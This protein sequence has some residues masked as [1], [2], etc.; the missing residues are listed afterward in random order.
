MMC[1]VS[2]LKE[3]SPFPFSIDLVILESWS[4]SAL[5]RSTLSAL[6]KVLPETFLENFLGTFKH[7]HHKFIINNLL[8]EDVKS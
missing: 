4:I 5:S 2:R 7:H 8:L 6:E 3:W 1:M